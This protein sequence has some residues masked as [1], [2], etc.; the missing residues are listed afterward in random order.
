VVGSNQLK[1]L[2]KW[3]Q[4]IKAE[5]IVASNLPPT[6]T[7]IRLFAC[8]LKKTNHSFVTLWDY[9]MILIDID[10]LSERCDEDDRFC[11]V[12]LRTRN[13]VPVIDHCCYSCGGEGQEVLLQ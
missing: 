10:K 11:V 7:T 2:K 13:D 4:K 5:A 3:G 6:L 12:C 8:S 9:K 1:I